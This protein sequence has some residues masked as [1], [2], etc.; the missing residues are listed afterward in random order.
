[1]S[2]LG[3]EWPQLQ[4]RFERTMSDWDALDSKA[5]GLIGVAAAI[6]GGLAAVH[7]AISRLWWLPCVVCA[8]AAVLFAAAMW[9]RDVDL[10]PNLVEAHD[11]MHA[12][13]A[14]ASARLMFDGVT[15]ASDAND[16]TYNRKAIWYQFGIAV[17]AAAVI[18]AIPVVVFRP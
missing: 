6:I 4:Q 2:E 8:I 3:Q 14:P 11:E 9:P 18:G 1:M 10:G 12:R 16:R 13:P 15:S 5:L 17:L 7:V